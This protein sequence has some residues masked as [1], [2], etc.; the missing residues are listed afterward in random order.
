MPERLIGADCKSAVP[1]GASGVQIP[2]SALMKTKQEIMMFLQNE[3]LI[4]WRLSTGS[5]DWDSLMNSQ[6][7][8]LFFGI[9]L[10]TS[11]EPSAGVPFDILQFF[12]IAEKLRQF[13]ELRKVIVLIADRHALTNSFMTKEIVKELC[14]QTESLL[15]AII[16]KFQLQSFEIKKASTMMSE[17]QRVSLSPKTSLSN[18][19]LIEEVSDVL[20]LMREE[21]LAIKLGWTIDGS[22]SSPGHDERFFDREIEK[23]LSRPISF[24]FTHAGRSFDRHR[25]KV[26]PY[27]AIR[28]ENRIILSPNEHVAEKL[29][30]AHETWGDSSLGGTKRHLANIVRLFESLFGHLSSMTLDEKV[31]H[32]LDRALKGEVV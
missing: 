11:K 23:F 30:V 18:Q 7:K 24:I 12:L 32:V 15:N 14:M 31:Q 20:W 2:L 21:K 28:G 9:G 5:I 27:I 16:E 17:A 8:S 26:C 10:C 3:P 22:I 19:Y 13:F 29:H 6:G 1:K 4:E 25:Q